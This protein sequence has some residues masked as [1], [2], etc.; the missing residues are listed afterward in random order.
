M[1]SNSNKLVE[2]SPRAVTA[3]RKRCTS[4]ARFSMANLESTPR[5]SG[6]MQFQRHNHRRLRNFNKPNRGLIT[7]SL[8][9]KHMP[10]SS[11]HDKSQCCQSERQSRV[12]GVGGI[13]FT[14]QSRADRL[15]HPPCMR[16]S[17]R[18]KAICSPKATQYI[19]S[20]QPDEWNVFSIFESFR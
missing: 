7:P 14:A 6:G 4:I 2:L 16:T 9:D 3:G 8:H 15:P 11:F 18:S 17:S 5:E 20:L 19:T 1:T 10:C 13:E 12:V